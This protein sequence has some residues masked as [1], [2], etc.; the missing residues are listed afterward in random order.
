MGHWLHRAKLRTDNTPDPTEKAFV[1]NEIV[2][3]ISNALTREGNQNVLDE[4]KDLSKPAKVKIFISGEKYAIDPSIYSPYLTDL[5][6]H[7][8]AEHNG[9]IKSELPNFDSK[10]PFLLFEDFNTKGLEGDPLEIEIKDIED[11]KKPHNF[12]FFWRAYGRSGK[13][14]GKMGSWGVGKSVFP[15]L[16]NINSFWALTIRESDKNAYLI[17][18]SVLRTHDRKDKPALCGYFP[19]G[20]FGKFEEDG[21]ALP[22]DSISEIKDFAKNFSLKRKIEVNNNDRANDTGVS[23][24]VPFP[25]IEVSL[26]SI[27]YSTVE[28]FFYPILLGKLDVEIQQED[29]ILHLSKEHFEDEISKIKFS[30]VFRARASAQ[31]IFKSTSTFAKWI[32][33]LSEGQ[34]IKLSATNAATSYKWVIKDLFK[35]I[36]IPSLQES[37]EKGIPLAFIIPIKFQP[38]G[39]VA[40]IR[41]FKAYIQKDDTL[42]EPENYFIRGYLTITGVKSLKKKGVR[43]IVI[44]DDK[45]LVTFFGHAEGPAHT[46]WH[47]DNFK[48]KYESVDQCI[49]YLQRSLDILYNNLIKPAENLNKDL[50]KDYFYIDVTDTNDKGSAGNKGAKKDKSPS[51]FPPPKPRRFILSQVDGGFKLTNNP[52]NELIPTDFIVRMAYMRLDSNPLAKY[53]E[54]DFDLKD[55][56]VETEN[57]TISKKEKNV[58]HVSPTANVFNMVIQGFDKRRDLFIDVK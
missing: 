2:G 41:Y 42:G 7:L 48:I 6:P 56:E 34:H 36:N 54:F 8:M 39:Q 25:K 35:N 30:Q 15:A 5:L 50:L 28:Q 21:F 12:H 55:F 58:I 46:G 20:Y 27:A 22:E 43:G 16:S 37:F 24:I 1:S 19:Y 11:A 32:I 49:S 9:I 33:S 47:K 3:N 29:R 18:Q 26:D 45:D 31:E 40:S 17:G 38:E 44:I 13:L 23:I 57:M 4:I 14:A 53:S 52:K 51:D 10:M